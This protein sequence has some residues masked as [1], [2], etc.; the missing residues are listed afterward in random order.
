[1]NITLDY[2]DPT[3]AHCK[4][5]V[6][7]DGALTGILTLRQDELATFQ[8]ILIHGMSHRDTFL[9]TGNPNPAEIAS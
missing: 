1:M 5:A 8:H 3:P 2:R 6:Y 7:L 9:A 4:V